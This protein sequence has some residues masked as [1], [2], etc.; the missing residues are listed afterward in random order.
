MIFPRRRFLGSFLFLPGSNL[1]ESLAAPVWQ[2]GNA[3]LLQTAVAPPTTSPVQFVDVA[4][5]AGLTSPNVWGGVDHKRYIIEAKGSGLAFFD[6]DQ[7]GWLDIYLT[8]GD[9]LDAHWPPGK[10]PTSQLYKNNRDGTFTD[11]TEKS[12]LARTG[13]QTGVCVGDYDNDGR[14]DLFCCFWG[15]N[16]LFHNNGDGTFTDVT[17]KAG[18]EQAKARWGAG[19]TFLDYDRD[20]HLDLFVCNYLTLDPRTIPPASDT[21]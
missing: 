6:Y 5:E 12:G 14:D 8:N 7:D 3:Y 18:L 15:H 19:F 16:I 10:A 21:R 1:A 2:W 9:R 20:C 11:V 4:K 13:W 17:H